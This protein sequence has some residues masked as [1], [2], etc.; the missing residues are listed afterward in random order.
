MSSLK[1]VDKEKR[2]VEFKR[3]KRKGF[4]LKAMDDGRS[5]L[6]H[7]RCSNCYFF[8]GGCSS[9]KCHR[10]NNELGFSSTYFVRI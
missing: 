8:L 10:I 9:E 3:N 4:L 1:L 7:F 2:L 5:G 6:F